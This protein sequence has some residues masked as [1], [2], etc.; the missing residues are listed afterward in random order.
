MDGWI[1]TVD[2]WISDSSADSRRCRL[3]KERYVSRRATRRS[4]CSWRSLWTSESDFVDLPCGWRL[5]AP[6]A[7]FAPIGPRYRGAFETGER[8]PK[9]VRVISHGI[10]GGGI[11]DSETDAAQDGGAGVMGKE[12][13]PFLG[14]INSGDFSSDEAGVPETADSEAEKSRTG[15]LGAS[16]RFT[17]ARTF[18]LFRR[19]AFGV[20]VEIP[21]EHWIPA[22]TH[23]GRYFFRFRGE[24]VVM[25]LWSSL[26]ATWLAQDSDG[27][28]LEPPWRELWTFGTDHTWECRFGPANDD[29]LERFRKQCYSGGDNAAS[30]IPGPAGVS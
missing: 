4:L 7:G 19:R 23:R 13:A 12:G 27:N 16:A 6:V 18:P 8:A 15:Y 26:P 25:G 1:L 29:D 3:R 22:G 17:A 20:S 14:G 24:P 21:P 11:N 30:I 2:C 10:D 5:K 9:R 28:P